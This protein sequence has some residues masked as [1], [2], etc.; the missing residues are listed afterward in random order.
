MATDD[1]QHIWNIID[2][3]G[4]IQYLVNRDIPLFKQLE[5]SLDDNGQRYLDSLIKTIEDAFPFNDV[6]YRSA[7]NESN[8]IVPSLDF[9]Q[10]YKIGV[11]TIESMRSQGLDVKQFLATID[12]FDFFAKYQ[13]VIEKLREDFGND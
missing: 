6:Y 9:D 10:V 12:K 4:K 5:N 7:K 13:D 2:N 3:R 11:D 1:L 8:T